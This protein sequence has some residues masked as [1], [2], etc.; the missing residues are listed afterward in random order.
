M[1]IYC[2]LA[3]FIDARLFVQKPHSITFEII[4]MT[5]HLS[6]GGS[7]PPPGRAAGHFRAT[8]KIRRKGKIVPYGLRG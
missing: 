6:G 4:N 5:G 2:L 3:V 8:T 7:L 1:H